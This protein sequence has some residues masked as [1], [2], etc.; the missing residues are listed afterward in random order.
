MLI[1]STLFKIYFI[2]SIRFI[3]K[4]ILLSLISLTLHY[5]HNLKMNLQLYLFFYSICIII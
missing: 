1:N 4:L 3:S 5:N 2:S